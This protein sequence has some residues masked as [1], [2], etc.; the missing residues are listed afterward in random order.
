MQFPWPAS[1]KSG[2]SSVQRRA[3]WWGGC[4]QCRRSR[5]KSPVSER[6][7]SVWGWSGGWHAGRPG[8]RAPQRDPP[9]V[10]GG[11]RGA[12]WW[13]EG[14]ALS[15]STRHWR[16]LSLMPSSP[17]PLVVG[18]WLLWTSSSLPIK[19]LLSATRH[20]APND[21]GPNSSSLQPPVSSCLAS[22]QNHCYLSIPNVLITEWTLSAYKIGSEF[23]MSI[24]KI[25]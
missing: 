10:G 18:V 25:M 3:P 11:P 9:W 7:A 6:R 14:V 5:D 23:F 22:S 24:T 4:R 12:R 15:G 13:S 8:F 19:A 1:C 2:Q 20:I 17:P 21:L 16:S